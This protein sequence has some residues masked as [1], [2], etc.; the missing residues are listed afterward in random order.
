MVLSFAFRLDLTESGAGH[1]AQTTLAPVIWFQ[2]LHAIGQGL[3]FAGLISGQLQ[4]RPE[5]CFSLG[6]RPKTLFSLN[7]FKPI[8]RINDIALILFPLIFHY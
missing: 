7:Y 6:T 4:V 2:P 1:E 5:L 3:H 8:A